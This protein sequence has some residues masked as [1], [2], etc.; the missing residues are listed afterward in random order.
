MKSL[1]PKTDNIQPIKKNKTS[2]FNS[3]R[4]IVIDNTQEH[5]FI[6]ILPHSMSMAGK[7]RALDNS[8]LVNLKGAIVIFD[9]K[10]NRCTRPAHH[11]VKAL[12]SQ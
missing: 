6:P 7:T 8:S 9:V 2:V 11:C 12:P 4:E 5:C 3:D 1:P 10:G